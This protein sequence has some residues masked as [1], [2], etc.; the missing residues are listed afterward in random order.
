M[1]VLISKDRLLNLLTNIILGMRGI[2]TTIT[3]PYLTTALCTTISAIMTRIVKQI[4]EPIRLQFKLTW[5]KLSDI[6]ISL[7]VTNMS[8]YGKSSVTNTPAY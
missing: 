7:T 4:H 6:F 5:Q 1:L 3:L 8:Y 2:S